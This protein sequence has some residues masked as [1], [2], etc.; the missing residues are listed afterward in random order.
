M[1]LR[2]DVFSS[3]HAADDDK[4]VTLANIYTMGMQQ[5]ML[6]TNMPRA[7]PADVAAAGFVALHGR[8]PT[9]TSTDAST[10]ARLLPRLC[11]AAPQPVTTALRRSNGQRNV[12]PRLGPSASDEDLL[13]PPGVPHTCLAGIF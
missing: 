5:A 4:L 11:A 9:N 12:R 10:I 7:R 3:R 2:S 13:F 8:R 6:P 1:Q